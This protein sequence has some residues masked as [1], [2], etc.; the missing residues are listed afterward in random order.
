[1]LIRKC[2][3]VF[4]LGRIGA[5]LVHAKIGPT[6]AKTDTELPGFCK[7]RSRVILLAATDVLAQRDRSPAMSHFLHADFSQRVVIDTAALPWQPSPSSTVFRKRLELIGDA[8]TGQVTSV[9][10]Y[11][12]GASFPLHGHPEGEEIFV[13]SGV[14]ADEHGSYTA[15]TYLLNPP[16]FTHAPFSEQG[17]VLFVKLGQYGGSGR[18]RVAIDTNETT[19]A[20]GSVRGA[21][22]LPLYS[23]PLFPESMALVRLTRNSTLARAACPGGEEIFVL[24]GEFADEEGTYPRW[25]WLRLP[26]GHAHEMRTK[27][28]ALLYVKRGHLSGRA[29]AGVSPPSPST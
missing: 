7:E 10:R 12:E 4:T 26:E 21:M 23:D 25:T 27:N 17:C 15:G 6:S 28:G 11:A 20:P 2:L 5:S 24:A 19:Y 13:I 8:E 16:G 14:F 22:R 18:Q 29:K 1:M 9:V 3:R